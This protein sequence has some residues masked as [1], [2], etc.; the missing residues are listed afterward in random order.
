MEISC[1]RQSGHGLVCT[2]PLWRA[3]QARTPIRVLAP[4]YFPSPLLP[5][6]LELLSITLNLIKPGITLLPT[7][8]PNPPFALVLSS[9]PP[10]S[11]G[12]SSARRLNTKCTRAS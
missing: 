1:V 7:F 11:F 10:Q 2:L 4:T 9:Q 8:L 12:A 5:V 6:L 3:E